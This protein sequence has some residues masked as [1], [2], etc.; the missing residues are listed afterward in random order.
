MALQS[1]T[2]GTLTTLGTKV[3]SYQHPV[4]QTYAPI[5]RKL[6]HVREGAG[7]FLDGTYLIAHPREWKDYTAETPQ[8]PTKKLKA[9]RNLAAYEN[10][11]STILDA[12]KSALFRERPVRRLEGLPEDAS[13]RGTIHDWWNGTEG[14]P[15][16]DAQWPLIWDAAA[17]FGH[18]VLYLEKDENDWPYL[19]AYTPLDVPDWM[20]DKRGNLTAVKFL[21]PVVRESLDQ[22]LETAQF[23]V[24]VVTAEGWTVYGQDG[25]TTAQGEHGM[26]KLPVVI[27]YGGRR[28]ITQVIGQSVLN[29]P[30]LYIDVYN[31]LSELRELLRNQTFS[32]LNVPLG[33]G[34]A[35]LS[36]ETAKAMLDATTGTENVLFSGLSA[37]FIAADA[38]NV[39]AY[40]EELDRRIRTIYRLAGIQWEADSRDAE[41]AGSLKIKR[42][43]MNQRLAAYGDEL[44][45][46]EMEL[47]DLWYRAMYAPEAGM[48]R[49][50]R[51]KPT[52]HYPDNFDVTPFEVVLQQAQSALALDYPERFVKELQKSL[53]G[54]FLPTASP[55]L[56]AELNVAIDQAVTAMVDPVGEALRRQVAA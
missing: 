19:C 56:I 42:E 27:L 48:V 24:R 32:I 16:L 21:E 26:G 43:D 6:A 1:G 4:Y 20:V 31:L 23:Q 10:F 41:A 15:S 51:E 30:K 35:A 11:A 34:D 7:G 8:V 52:I 38:S 13:R 18:V 47:A 49:K 40:Q 22:P 50:E 55:A 54:K 36:V 53:V 12:K 25:K 44:E 17:T 45:R 2:D 14:V 9:R 29:D 5:W 46:V 37:G 28:P 39:K 3:V 33:T